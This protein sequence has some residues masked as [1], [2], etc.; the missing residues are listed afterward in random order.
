MC[1]RFLPVS[2][3]LIVMFLDFFKHFYYTSY[4]SETTNTKR[5]CIYLGKNNKRMYRVTNVQCVKMSR[6]LS[7]EMINCPRD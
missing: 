5:H 7:V 2:E 6:C 4:F 3:L 1:V